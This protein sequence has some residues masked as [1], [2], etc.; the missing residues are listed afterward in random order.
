MKKIFT[1]IAILVCGMM[2]FSCK[3]GG[4]NAKDAECTECTECTE[5]CNGECEKHKAAAGLGEAVEAVETA[6]ETATEAAAKGVSEAEKA[7]EKLGGVANEAMLDVKPLFQGGDAN[8]FQKYIQQNV[9]YPAIA[10][11]NGDQGR[12]MV[13]FV[14]GPDGKIGNV[15]VVKGVSEAL[16]AEAVRVVSEAPAWTAGQLKG[17]NVPVAYTLPVVFQLR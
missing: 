10:I 13:T 7:L 16:D 2:V 4:K 3:N 14:V 9:K 17:Q 15:K 12:V 5:E 6:A 1:V 8:A 11:E